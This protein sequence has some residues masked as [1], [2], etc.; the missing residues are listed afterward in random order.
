MKTEALNV[1]KTL[2]ENLLKEL[3]KQNILI[4]KNTTQ[5]FDSFKILNNVDQTSQASSD[6]TLLE[7][8][9]IMNA[10]KTPDTENK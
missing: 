10:T 4:N 7:L 1:D 6:Q 3:I 2:V 9:Q 8:P 5:G